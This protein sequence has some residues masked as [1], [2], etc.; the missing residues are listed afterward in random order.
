MGQR[1]R[2]VGGPDQ[3]EGAVVLGILE[4]DKSVLE[5]VEPIGHSVVDIAID[6]SISDEAV[7][8]LGTTHYNIQITISSQSPQQP[9]IAQ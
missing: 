1:G 3:S 5:G 4:G 9:S 6:V 7:E 2:G 8:D